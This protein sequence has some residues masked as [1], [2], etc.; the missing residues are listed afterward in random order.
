MVRHNEP[1][2]AQTEPYYRSDIG[3]PFGVAV[4]RSY[5][6]TVMMIGYSGGGALGGFLATLVGWRW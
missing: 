6:M 5:F 4:L 1:K 3:G 2:T